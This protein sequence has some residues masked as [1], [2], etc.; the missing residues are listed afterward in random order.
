MCALA[1]GST[2]EGRRPKFRT[3]YSSAESVDSAGRCKVR[4]AEYARLPSSGLTANG[5][6]F[7]GLGADEFDWFGD[8]ARCGCSTSSFGTGLRVGGDVE[9]L[10]PIGEWLRGSSG[11]VDDLSEALSIEN[12]LGG[13][14]GRRGG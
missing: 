1:S 11:G 9:P 6:G 10:L 4:F 8:G 5:F 7:V 2:A 14:G 12:G 13:G 3:P